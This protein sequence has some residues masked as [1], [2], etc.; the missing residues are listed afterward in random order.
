VDAGIARE[1][2]VHHG[3]HVVEGH[4]VVGA[5]LEQLAPSDGR[6]AVVGLRLL[7]SHSHIH[8]LVLLARREQV[9]AAPP[10]L[11]LHARHEVLLRSLNCILGQHRLLGVPEQEVFEQREWRAFVSQQHRVPGASSTCSR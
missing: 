6:R 10:S 5:L 8:E 3:G 2:G 4:L 9:Q 11:H 1:A 7:H